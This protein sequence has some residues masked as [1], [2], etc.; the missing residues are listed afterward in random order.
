MATE[1]SN[2]LHQRRPRYRGAY[3]RHF[4]EKYKELH[5]E[6]YQDEIAKVVRR[7]QTPAGTHRPICVEEILT[8]LQPQP[9]EVGI[10]ATLGFGGHTIELLN[11][12]RPGGHLFGLD[13]DPIELPKTEARLRQMGFGPDLLTV[14][15]M[16]FAGLL[17]L[18]PELPA[19]V[20][21]LLADLGVSSMQLDNPDR[22]FTYKNRG[23][24]DLRLNPEHGQSAAALLRTASEK[25]LQ[26]MLLTN[27]DEPHAAAIAAAVFQRRETI[28]ST[29]DLTA[30]VKAAL[31]PL[32]LHNRE[33]ETRKTLQRTFQAF[34]IAVNDEFS[35]LE[36]L[37]RALPFVLKS[38]G[39]IAIL[40]FH[41]G[42]DNR[43]IRAFETGLAHGDYT[44][45]SEDP[46]RP[47]PQERYDNPRS[48]CARLRWAVKA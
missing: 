11:R 35:A 38:G 43:V 44:A 3:P 46:I 9:G 41:S 47:A 48:K 28:T 23:P 34:R 37:L 40:T 2:P 21:F 4:A 45:I 7:G 30:A 8:V 29:T 42:E 26:K 14:R 24:L 15:K 16:N 33:E 18:Q 6:Q 12:I 36:Q 10:D 17:K 27:A 5:P 31:E 32:P 13:V 25:T 1:N 20:D 39:R 19:G 22:G